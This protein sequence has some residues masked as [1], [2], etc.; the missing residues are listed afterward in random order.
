MDNERGAGD[1]SV[2]ILTVPFECVCVRVRV[3]IF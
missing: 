1:F 2:Q 3:Y